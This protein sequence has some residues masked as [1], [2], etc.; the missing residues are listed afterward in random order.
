MHDL[1]IVTSGEWVMFALV[2]VALIYSGVVCMNM[3]KTLIREEARASFRT[4]PDSL[5]D[6]RQRG[7]RKSDRR[8]S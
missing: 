8:A 2:G 5:S 3:R 6:L 1:M 4:L 7:T